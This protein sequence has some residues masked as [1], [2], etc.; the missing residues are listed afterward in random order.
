MTL[1]PSVPRR[2]LE[3]PELVH[4]LPE[5]IKEP[6]VYFVGGVVR[7]AYLRRPL[8]DLDLATPDD[9]RPLARRI[10]NAFNGAYYPLDDE[11]RVG[12]AI[13][14]WEGLPRTVDVAA[15]READLLADLRD[16]DFTINAIAVSL[17]NLERVI[18]PLDGIGALERK[19]LVLCSPASIANDPVRALRAIRL[20]INFNLRFSPETKAAIRHDGPA[21]AHSSPERVRDELFKI[22]NTTRPS[23]ALHLMDTLGLLEI[24]FPDAVKMKGVTQSPPHVFDVWRHTLSV[25][26]SLSTLL[27]TISPQR[28]DNDAANFGL[29]MVAFSLSH[30]REQLQQHLA[31]EWPNER[32]H[33]ALMIL[34]A[35]LHDIA[36]P[37]TR[38]VGDDGRIHFYEHETV[39][40]DVARSY[41]EKF[42][43]SN[44]EIQRMTTIIRQHLRPIWLYQAEKVT[45]RAFYRFW[46]DL[47]PAGV[48]VC[49]LSIADKLGTYGPTLQ[50]DMWLRF[51]ELQRRLLETYFLENET[52]VTFEPLLN[53]HAL[54]E[55]FD[56]E[57]G[58]IIGEILNALRE[59]QAMGEIT[60]QEEA[61]EWAEDWLRHRPS[62]QDS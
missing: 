5:I 22:F 53:G 32:P 41:G 47:G 26:D 4:Q 9:G 61:Y 48:D 54:M 19:Q 16:R 10:A 7:D 62:P 59:A 14:E 11:R 51:V 30:L 49:L 37:A 60:S 39:G 45:R 55:H 43:L 23:A 42:K 3:W 24:I 58:P 40:A 34:V 18:D 25:I 27:K 52:M 17:H 31:A 1:S 20:S 33:T 46:R 38:S 29:G 2:P 44:D 28:S 21:L 15:F 12:R 8:H 50:Q 56:L 36:K 57:P 6:E 13:I 35:L